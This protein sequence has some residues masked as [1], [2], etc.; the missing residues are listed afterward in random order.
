M[1]IFP[2]VSLLEKDWYMPRNHKYNCQFSYFAALF[3]TQTFKPAY[4]E[5]QTPHCHTPSWQKKRIKLVYSNNFRRITP[6]SLSSVSSE[7]TLPHSVSVWHLPDTA[8]FVLSLPVILECWELINSRESCVKFE[9]E[10]LLPLSPS[11]RSKRA[12]EYVSDGLRNHKV[13]YALNATQLCI[14]MRTAQTCLQN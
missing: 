4:L 12:L 2:S 13:S 3:L 7:Y 9:A 6:F 8:R 11:V 14:L 1:P 10:D 5:Y